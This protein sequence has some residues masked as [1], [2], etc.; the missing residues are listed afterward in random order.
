MIEKVTIGSRIVE[1]SINE[2][3]KELVD[4]PLN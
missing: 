1:V 3:V 2:L 4:V